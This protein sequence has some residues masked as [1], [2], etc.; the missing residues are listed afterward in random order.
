MKKLRT[1]L[2]AAATLLITTAYAQDTLPAQKEYPPKDGGTGPVVVLVSG[3]TGPGNYNGLASGLA[4]QGFDVVLVDGNDFWAKGVAGGK[5]LLGVIEHAQTGSHAAPGKVG[6]VGASLG[7]ATALTYA[8]RMPQHVGAIVAQYPL[9][10][11]IKDPA[12]FTGK[13]KVPVL[14]LAGT[15]DSY[16]GCCLIDMA[17][18]LGEAAKA[19]GAPLELV[20]YPGADH[21]FSTDNSKHREVSADSLHRTAEFLHQKLGGS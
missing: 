1:A 16:K 14:M 20:E 12:D 9:T 21:G 6:V 5:L 3:Q 19:N 7:G 11:F 4:E 13:M 10:S 18:K 8:T 2:L 17:R 15:F